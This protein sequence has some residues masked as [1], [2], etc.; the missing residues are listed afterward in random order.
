MLGH[1]LSMPGSVLH[2]SNSDYLICPGNIT[3]HAC[4]AIPSTHHRLTSV[5]A[6]EGKTELGLETA[7]TTGGGA[8]TAGFPSDSSA[9]SS[10]LL[11]S[12]PSAPVGKPMSCNTCG[13]DRPRD[14]MTKGFQGTTYKGP[15]TYSTE[16][17]KDNLQHN[18]GYL[19]RFSPPFSFSGCPEGVTCDMSKD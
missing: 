10:P 6:S 16:L 11:E 15:F 3:H 8:T 9:E 18:L 7:S 14:Q 2:I 1:K 17:P 19:Q 13:A 4:S 12:L 5:V